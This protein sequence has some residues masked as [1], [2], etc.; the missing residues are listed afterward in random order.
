MSK[1]EKILSLIKEISN[2]NPVMQDIFLRGS[3]LNFHFILK[4]VFADAK[5]YFNIDHV[6]SKIDERY[7]DITGEISAKEVA[8]QRYSPIEDIY[9]TKYKTDESMRN[10]EMYDPTDKTK[11][12]R[13]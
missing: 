3:C 4:E 5:A 2:S 11:Y 8:K 7:Y 9:A 13:E 1:H 12:I 6:I 10:G